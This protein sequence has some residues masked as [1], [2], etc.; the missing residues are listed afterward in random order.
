MLTLLAAY[1]DIAGFNEIS[2]TSRGTLVIALTGK[3]D[4]VAV[5]AGSVSGAAVEIA[6]TRQGPEGIRTG[7]NVRIVTAARFMDSLTFSAGTF[8]IDMARALADNTWTTDDRAFLIQ[9]TVKASEPIVVMRAGVKRVRIELGRGNDVATL[10]TDGID[11]PVTVSG[12]AGNDFIS[13]GGSNASLFGDAD[14][15]QLASARN[16]VGGRG[17]DVLMDGRFVDGGGG[18]DMYSGRKAKRIR[19]IEQE[20]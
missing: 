2:L 16:L 12:G 5:T 11:V 8:G 15:D 6:R 3:N 13:G 4:T 7:L 10:P 19:R 9:S 18:N 1:G 17:D 20:W 14:N